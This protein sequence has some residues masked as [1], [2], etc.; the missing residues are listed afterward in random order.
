MKK[1]MW[2]AGCM[3]VLFSVLIVTGCSK[4][5]PEQPTTSG[6]S[7]DSSDMNADNMKA[8]ADDVKDQAE[9][10]SRDMEDMA[11]DVKQDA[12]TASKEALASIEQK[13]CPVMGNPID[14]DVFVEYKGKKVYFCC[15]AC[16]AEF[17]KDPDKYISKLPQFQK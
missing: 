7:S 11:K 4:K 8:M 9:E 3:L 2:I 12:E 6:M 16:I 17:E 13:T 10:T 1:A 14:P 15:K 5:E